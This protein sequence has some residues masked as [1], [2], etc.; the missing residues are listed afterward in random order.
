[1]IYSKI[2]LL[3]G[4]GMLVKEIMTK[5]VICLNMNETVRDA[6]KKLAEHN[7]SGA[8]V[9]DDNN[10]LVGIFT[11][12]DII[13]ILRTSYTEMRMIYPSIHAFGVDFYEDRKRKEIKKALDEISSM[14]VG[15]V[16]TRR[17][18]VVEPDDYVEDAGPVMIEKKINRLPVLEN[19]KIVGIITRGDII[20][21]MYLNKE[22]K[23]PEC[24]DTEKEN[25]SKPKKKQKE[26]ELKA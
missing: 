25:L 8:P 4:V 26:K 7:I 2:P 3:Y 15:D 16:M 1:M 5:N 21:A 24:V 14:K 6:V 11:E 12:A 19:G 10:R 18:Y 17:V 20:Q 22:H 23:P 9:V 13:R